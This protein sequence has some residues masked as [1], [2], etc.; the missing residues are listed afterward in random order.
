ML[1]EKKITKVL[2]ENGD[3]IVGEVVTEKYSNGRV[4]H[5]YYHLEHDSNKA[6][7]NDEWADAL[8]V[9][10]KKVEDDFNKRFYG[11]NW[12]GDK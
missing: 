8:F 11:K 6:L 4:A 3:N 7:A 1:E 5:T 10:G 12:K 9:R 2:S